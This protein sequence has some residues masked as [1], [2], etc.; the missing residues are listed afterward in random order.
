MIDIMALLGSMT[1]VIKS[2]SGQPQEILIYLYMAIVTF[3]MWKPNILEKLRGKKKKKCY[4]K[5][6]LYQIVADKAI[7][8]IRIREEYDFK[9]DQVR[10]SIMRDQMAF[11]ENALERIKNEQFKAYSELLKEKVESMEN[12]DHWSTSKQFA[13]NL[14]I[15]DK[16][17]DTIFKE[18]LG[19]TRRAFRDNGLDKMTDAE[20]E[21]Y[22]QDLAKT[23]L[24][25]GEIVMR[26][27]YNASVMIL[28]YDEGKSTVNPKESF[29]QTSD[30]FRHARKISLKAHKEIKQLEEEFNEE[31][32]MEMNLNEIIE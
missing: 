6:E 1:T 3:L 8:C 5:E 18:V 24:A 10:H 15:Y 11:A 26:Q 30:V 29:I 12:V 4:E 22:V 20:F 17:L 9:I 19:E 23:C 13:A 25:R 21:L 14:Q 2:T 7:D 32:S 28:T 16:L 31:L 27:Q